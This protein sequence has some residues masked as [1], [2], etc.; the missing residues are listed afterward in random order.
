MCI[1]LAVVV[2]SLWTLISAS[3]SSGSV[4]ALNLDH[5]SNLNSSVMGVLETIYGTK[6][7][8]DLVFETKFTTGRSSSIEVVRGGFTPDQDFCC[9]VKKCTTISCVENYLAVRK[10]IDI[11]GKGWA[12]EFADDP[13]GVQKVLSYCS[14]TFS[15]SFEDGTF[16]SVDDANARDNAKESLSM[17]GEE[18]RSNSVIILSNTTLGEETELG[19]AIVAF[20]GS[21]G[22]LLTVIFVS[23]YCRYYSYYTT[24][25]SSS[26]RQ[27]EWQRGEGAI[28]VANSH[29]LGQPDEDVIPV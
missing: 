12:S 4:S 21:L 17:Y 20:M 23:R 2:I 1:F 3:I 24:T 10:S 9:S 14:S 25:S 22:L 29:L 15:C 28:E 18:Y 19:F 11:E 8:S 16:R 26:E 13:D 27:W 5:N 6:Y 7:V